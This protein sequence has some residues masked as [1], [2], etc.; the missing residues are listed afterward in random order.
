M[1]LTLWTDK[2]SAALKRFVM[3]GASSTKSV[4][5]GQDEGDS[6]VTVCDR[7]NVVTVWR[8]YLSVTRV[9]GLKPDPGRENAAD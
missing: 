5:L 8:N 3:G 4:T 2:C 9:Y 7:Y 6:V 1:L